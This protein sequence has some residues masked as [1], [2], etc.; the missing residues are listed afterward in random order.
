MDKSLEIHRRIS[1]L[2]IPEDEKQKLFA[3]LADFTEE[4]ANKAKK[5]G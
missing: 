3:K 5:D 4:L 1:E 2:N